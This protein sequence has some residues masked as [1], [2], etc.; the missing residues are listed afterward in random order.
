V[1]YPA[2]GERWFDFE[3]VRALGDR[4]SEVLLI[5]L[6]GH[7]RGHCGVAVNTGDGWL[8][9]A[10]DAYFYRSELETPRRHAPIATKLYERF[11]QMQPTSRVANQQRL[12][13]LLH[14]HRGY[15]QILC[16]HDP[17]ELAW[18]QRTGSADGLTYPKEA[19]PATLIGRL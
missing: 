1:R 6:A 4:D 14:T 5:P 13:D 19:H 15:V 11:M 12:A 7:S 8:L 18:S 16:S 9:H 10:G 3:G 2:T 17:E